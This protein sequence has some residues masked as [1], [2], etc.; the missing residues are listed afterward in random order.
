MLQRIEEIILMLF[1]GY[2]ELKR[3]WEITNKDLDTEIAKKNNYKNK[4]E[5]AENMIEELTKRC[6]DVIDMVEDTRLK[7]ITK[8][9][10]IDK[11]RGLE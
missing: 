7:R 10:I 1:K 2:R 3:D 6:W 5:S 11:L 8:D 9:K 4:L